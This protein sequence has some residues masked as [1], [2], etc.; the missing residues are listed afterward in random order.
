MD[1]PLEA[2]VRD[3]AFALGVVIEALLSL[4][5]K[6]EKRPFGVRCSRCGHVARTE[7]ELLGG[8]DVLSAPWRAGKR[9]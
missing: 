9:I 4:K 5:H 8:D 2:A 1:G 3:L 6:P 7:H